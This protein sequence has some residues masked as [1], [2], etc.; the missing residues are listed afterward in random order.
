MGYIILILILILFLI[1]LNLVNYILNNIIKKDYSR[2]SYYKYQKIIYNT[3]IIMTK[4]DFIASGRPI[5]KKNNEYR[6]SFINAY[7][8][9]YN[10]YL[11]YIFINNQH[12]T[13][14]FI[15]YIQ[16]YL[17]D[18][19]IT[20]NNLK[21]V[22]T[23]YLYNYDDI[24]KNKLNKKID[25]LTNGISEITPE[26][27]FDLRKNI[28]KDLPGVYIIHN[29]NNGMYYVGQ[30]VHLYNRVNQHFTGHGNG[31]VY[32]D[33]KR[34]GDKFTIKL[35]KLKNSGYTNLDKLEKDMITK[36]DA[37]NSGYNKTQGNG[38]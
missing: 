38:A 15:N 4:Q 12:F 34:G 27:F 29:I 33:Y 28:N 30:S 35:I 17:S 5:Y 21:M 20:L 22:I 18:N 9:N 6:Q 7:N 31:D 19:K 2:I 26:E 23:D 10:K 32:A 8:T 36:Y 14:D 11:T 25:N 24:Q 1:M 3:S 13:N 37:L 16:P